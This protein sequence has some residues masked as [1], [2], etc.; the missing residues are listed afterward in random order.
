MNSLLP[1]SRRVAFKSTVFGILSIPV[2]NVLFAEKLIFPTE[3]EIAPDNSHRYPAIS[4]SIVSE[5]V[6]VSHFN[7]DRLKELVEPRP[8]LARAVWDW[9]FG[10]WESAL[11]AASHVG[12]KD[13]ADYLMLKGARPDIF[14]YAMLGAFEVVKVMI[15]MTPG[16][17]K[18]AGPHGISLLQH[19]KNG[20]A[21]NE[22]KTGARY[23]L[24]AYLEEL[25]NADGNNYSPMSEEEN[26]KYIG[27]YKYGPND[28]EGFSV[29]QNMR[30]FITLGK[31][32]KNGGSLYPT[33]ENTFMYNGAPSVEV[34]FV[35]NN[36]MVEKLIV[37]EP[38]FSVTA[39]KI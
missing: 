18:I 10:D 23:E 24:I 38:G 9:G 27:D 39:T 3:G 20:I 34:S 17:Q 28:H 13:I 26:K 2:S 32:G 30:K 6:G 11:G 14:T 7:L 1:I 25:G 31:L 8:E 16:V 29:K 5:V 33:S 19:V 15:E 21:D 22:S 35:W 36:G 12:R 4:E 37:K